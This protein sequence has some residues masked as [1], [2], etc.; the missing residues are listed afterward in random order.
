AFFILLRHIRIQGK[1][2]KNVLVIIDSGISEQ[3][4]APVSLSEHGYR[5]TQHVSTTSEKNWL[6]RVLGIVSTQGIHEVW[7]QLPISQ[8]DEIKRIVYTLRHVTVDIRYMPDLG[9]LPVLNHQ[10]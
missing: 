5:I 7:I 4:I 6:E 2:L 9:D 8:G 10:I 1:N 3:A